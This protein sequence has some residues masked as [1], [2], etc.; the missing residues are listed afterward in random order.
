MGRG[1]TNFRSCRRALSVAA[2][3]PANRAPLR[4]R[5]TTLSSSVARSG[6]A[7]AG[8]CLAL[9]ELGYGGT[10]HRICFHGRALSMDNHTQ[11]ALVTGGARGI[12][13]A[14]SERL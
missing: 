8:T 6:T 3:L 14:I 13:R 11:V 5:G 1:G 12:G 7:C 9:L 10:E 4:R 2:H